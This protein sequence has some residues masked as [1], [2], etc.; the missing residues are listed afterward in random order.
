MWAHRI[1]QPSSTTK[2]V[3]VVQAEQGTLE[4]I[5]LVLPI[6]APAKT[7]SRYTTVMAF[8]SYFSYRILNNKVVSLI[9][10]ENPGCD[11]I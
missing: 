1:L 7:S 5:R 2:L 11:S 4:L 10:S 9:H 6:P 3:F 8:K